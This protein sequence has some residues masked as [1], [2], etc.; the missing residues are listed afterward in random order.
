MMS[1]SELLETIEL[2][3]DCLQCTGDSYY[4][5]V[6]EP[7]LAILRFYV[8]GLCSDG[9]PYDNIAKRVVDNI[10]RGNQKPLSNLIEANMDAI[11]GHYEGDYSRGERGKRALI[12]AAYR[13]KAN[14]DNP[15]LKVARHLGRRTAINVRSMCFLTEKQNAETK[16]DTVAYVASGGA[17]PALLIADK[18]SIRDVV[19]IRY[20]RISCRDRKTRVPSCF[21]EDY[22]SNVFSGKNVLVAEDSTI[23]GE[24][25]I[26]VS[27]RIKDY[28]PKEIY[29]AIVAPRNNYDNPSILGRYDD[30]FFALKLK[31]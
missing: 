24:S 28:H 1:L 25:V 16:F 13:V 29:M 7:G 14:I 10:E 3:P 22:L 17:E 9:S 4:D 11:C 20:S 31:E 23:T 26:A 21:T 8:D 12:E 27:N 5:S 2:A 19:P 18:L 6:I 30:S 15:E